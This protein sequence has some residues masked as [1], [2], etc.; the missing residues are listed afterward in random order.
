MDALDVIAAE[1]AEPRRDGRT[2][3]AALREVA[4]VAELVHQLHEQLRA[5]ARLETGLRGARE[6]P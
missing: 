4:L 1:R 3:I 6:K 2:D 5:G